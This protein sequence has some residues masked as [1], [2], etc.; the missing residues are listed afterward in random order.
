M[1]GQ[2]TTLP[3]QAGATSLVQRARLAL[4]GM[5]GFIA[6]PA[7]RRALPAIGVLLVVTLGLAAWLLLAPANRVTLHAGLPEAEKS[8]ALDALTAAGMDARLDP[9]SGALTVA[10]DQFHSARMLLATQGL[11]EGAT[12][13]MSAIDEMPMGTS[14]QI[15]SARL[16]RMQ[17]LDLARSIQELRPVRAARVHL[18][19]PERSAFVRD[20]QPPRASVFLELAPGMALD[21]AQ[22]R[23]IVSLVAAAV[24]DMPRGNVSVVDQTG[25]LL[26]SPEEDPVQAEA[27]RQMQHQR[28]LETLYRDRVLSLLTPIVG[29][30]NAAVEVTLDMDFTRSEITSEEYLPDTALRSEQSSSQQTSGAQAGGIPG[31]VANTPPNEAQMAEAAT[32]GAKSGTTNS[33]TSSTR[34]YEVS[35]RVETRQPQTAQI[36]RVHAA[37][38][39]HR[40]PTPAAP[41]E[42]EATSAAPEAVPLAEIEAL[43]RS[44]IGYNAERGDIVTVASAPF[45]VAPSV[46]S[47]E[48][49]YDAAWLP[50]LGRTLAQLALFGIIVLG[51]V[52]PI[53]NRLLPPVGAT[54]ATGM[55]YGDA[56]E[57]PR[58]ESLSALRQR[59]ETAAPNAE[60]LNGAIT[61]E[62]KIDLLRQMAGSETNRIAGVFKS[63]ITPT[64]EDRP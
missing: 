30:G 2:Q 59:L 22:V 33:A 10:A 12:D 60:D 62:E 11:P 44:A 58:G 26:T 18:A 7:L 24:P 36:N 41:A 8:L 56:I 23:A 6:Q 31:A 29:A 19:L 63:M 34:N 55:T 42:G 37:V 47:A 15:E 53:L 57:V 32:Q 35:R 21:Q 54:A 5:D 52:R 13:G 45:V 27:D 61:Y 25:T 49:W 28:R 46:I 50:T 9:S 14:R 1:D 40:L 17:E 3:A 43:T 39:L 4:S 16:R 38:L 20:S 48:R 64:G 51:V